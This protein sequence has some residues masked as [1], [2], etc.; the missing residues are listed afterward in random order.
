MIYYRDYLVMVSSLKNV[1]NHLRREKNLF[2]I[3]ILTKDEI[4]LLTQNNSATKSEK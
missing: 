1:F 3:G 2:D 4:N